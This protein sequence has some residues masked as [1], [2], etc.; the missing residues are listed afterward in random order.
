MGRV[1]NKNNLTEASD[2]ERNH[3]IVR[4]ERTEKNYKG[5]K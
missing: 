1:G 2:K 4:S 5:V 3:E